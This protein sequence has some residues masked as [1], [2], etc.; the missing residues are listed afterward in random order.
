MSAP[1][2]KVPSSSGPCV[3][4]ALHDYQPSCEVHLPHSRRHLLSQSVW[5]TGRQKLK[6]KD[7]ERLQ[8]RKEIKALHRY[9]SVSLLAYIHAN[10]ATNGENLRKTTY[11]MLNCDWPSKP[12]KNKKR[13]F[14][15]LLKPKHA[16]NT[17]H[18]AP[19]RGSLNVFL[20]SLWVVKYRTYG[21]KNT[22]WTNTLPFSTVPYIQKDIHLSHMLKHLFPFHFFVLFSEGITYS[23]SLPTKKEAATHFARAFSFRLSVWLIIRV[24]YAHCTVLFCDEM[25][26]RRLPLNIHKQV[27]FAPW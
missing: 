26:L 20:P 11:S 13:D 6:W 24:L 21:P 17:S 10:L 9:Q 22:I 15:E 2:Q 12:Q 1:P 16:H 18:T 25:P 4:L 8:W 19:S 27:N 23:G 7:S 5:E 14:S 3:Q